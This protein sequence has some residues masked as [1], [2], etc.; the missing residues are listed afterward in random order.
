VCDNVI[1]YFLFRAEWKVKLCLSKPWKHIEGRYIAPLILNR[2]RL[3]SRP[4]HFTP[5]KR[6]LDPLNRRLDGCLGEEK[7]LLLLP[8]NEPQTVQTIVWS[9]YLQSYPYKRSF[10]S[11]IVVEG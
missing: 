9:L 2:G 11:S 1:E 5:R 6:A 3:I 8:G 4:G 7:N 10:S